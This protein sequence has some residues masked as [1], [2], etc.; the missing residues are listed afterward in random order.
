MVYYPKKRSA[1]KEAY[2]EFQPELVAAYDSNYQNC[3]IQNAGIVRNKLKIEASSN[4]K[5][6]LDIQR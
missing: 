5:I 6:F 1:Y 3:L 4:A 2:N